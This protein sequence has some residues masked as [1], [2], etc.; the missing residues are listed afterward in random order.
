MPTVSWNWGLEI[1]IKF[2]LREVK[3]VNIAYTPGFV[4]YK[5]YFLCTLRMYLNMNTQNELNMNTQNLVVL[6]GSSYT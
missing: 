5:W 2:S 4:A 3:I 6:D 1:D